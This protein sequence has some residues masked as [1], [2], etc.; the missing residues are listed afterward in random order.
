MVNLRNAVIAVIAGTVG[1]VGIVANREGETV[2]QTALCGYWQRRRTVSLAQ[3]V[4][5][6][7]L[8]THLLS[9]SLT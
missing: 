7:H 4:V 3:G 5:R 2:R 1:I 8:L 9:L 6:L